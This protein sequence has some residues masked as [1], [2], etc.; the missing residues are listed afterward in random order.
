MDESRQE[1]FGAIWEL[2]TQNDTDEIELESEDEYV[3]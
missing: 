1:G 2:A 3:E